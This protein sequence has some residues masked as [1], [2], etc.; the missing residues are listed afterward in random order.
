MTPLPPATLTFQ[1]GVD[2][3]TGTIDTSLWGSEATISHADA[4]KLKIDAEKNGFP[5]HSL[6]RFDDIFGN[7]AGQITSADT[8]D[9]AILEFEVTSKNGDAI[10]VYQMLQSWS[11]T[12]TW[13]QWGDGIQTNGLE[14]G[15]TPI[16]A[17]VTSVS[18][19]L[20]QLDITTAVQ[21]WQ[22][23]P[24][25]NYGLALLPTGS[26]GVSLYSSEGNYVPRLVVEVNQD[27][28]D[29]RATTPEPIGGDD[30]L[31]GGSGND[32]LIGGNGN[33]ILNGTDK[34]AMG[35][36]EQD[37]LTGGEGKD[38]FILGD[39]VHV[40]YS[41]QGN[42]DFATITDFDAGMDTVQLLG[43][44]SYT[45]QTQGNDVHL[46]LNNSDPTPDDLI[47]VFTGTTSLDLSS[48][49]FSYV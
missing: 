1:Q 38:L 30:N 14:A 19:G 20:L 25:Q 34:I 10:E 31:N 43:S 48:S 29:S 27:S 9:S 3:Y 42:A 4:D 15:S 11:E 7:Q 5:R 8:I 23:N 40:Y 49:A 41:T 46:Y 45:Q 17:T 24:F 37:S 35:N 18:Q 36:L 22:N 44:A 47:A 6:I 16:T 12:D 32:I 21:S 33:D 2:G 13:D 26:D 39:T 28:A